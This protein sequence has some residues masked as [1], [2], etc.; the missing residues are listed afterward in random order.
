MLYAGTFDPITNGHLDLIRRASRICEELV[1]GVLTNPAKKTKYSMDERLEMIRLATESLDNVVTD[2]FDGLLAD[3]VVNNHISTVLRGL[4]AGID[5]E[6]EI[7]MAQ[8]NA[9]LY[10]ERTET[11]FMMTDPS[12]SFISSSIVKEVFSYGGDI[13]GLV[14]TQVYEYMKKIK[15]EKGDK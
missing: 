11:I 9:R 2:H 15:E 1:V 4:R 13:S 12:H 10:K 14:P 7:Q 8:M 3:Y 5:F 6:N